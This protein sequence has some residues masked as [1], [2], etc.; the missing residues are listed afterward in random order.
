MF[1][2]DSIA[3][4]KTHHGLFYFTHRFSL[5][6]GPVSPCFSCFIFFPFQA[7]TEPDA[8]RRG[9]AGEEQGLAL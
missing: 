9:Y 3:V 5:R 1:V 2:S 7:A 8:D 6:W 4:F